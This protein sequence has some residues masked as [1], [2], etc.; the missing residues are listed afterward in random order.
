MEVTKNGPLG[1]VV[2][3]QY[4][5]AFLGSCAG[6]ILSRRGQNDSHI[7]FTIIVEDDGYWFVS[8][9]GFSSTWLQ[10]LRGVLHEASNWIEHECE[11]DTSGWKFKE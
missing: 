7:C 4:E 5:K 1:R 6:V 10:E 9:H 2:T 3:V 11:K 8:Q